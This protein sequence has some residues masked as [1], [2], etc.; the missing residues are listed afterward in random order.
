M[1]RKFLL[2]LL[3]ILLSSLFFVSLN[4]SDKSTATI[5]NEESQP[6]DTLWH[7]KHFLDW[8]KL[9]L[10]KQHQN[11]RNNIVVLKND[12]A[13]LPIGRLD[14][15]IVWVSF[16]GLSSG[17][18]QGMKNYTS[19]FQHF[20]IKSEI[21]LLHTLPKIH[22]SDLV[23][24][25][26]HGE[27]G[28]IHHEQWQLVDK[29]TPKNK[30][31]LV[32]FGNINGHHKEHQFQHFQSLVFAPDNHPIMQ[33]ETAQL[34]FGAFGASAK[35]DDHLNKEFP[36]GHGM[37]TVPNGRFSF[38][39]PEEFGISASQLKKMD[40]I[41]LNGIQ[42]GAYPGCQILATYKGSVIYNKCFGNK[43]YKGNDPVQASDVYDIASVTKIAA[44]TLLAM[45]LHSQ[46]KFDLNKKLGDYLGDWTKNTVY[47]SVS[48]KDMMA[49][50][51]GFTPW[52]PFYKTTLKNGKTNER[53]YS[54]EKKEGFT[55]QV[56]ANLFLRND[57]VDSMYAQIV[58][59]PLNTP[60]K[61]EYSDLCF[62]FVQRINELQT[63]RKQNDYLEKE[64]YRPMG[65]HR[66]GYLPYNRI[67]LT[68]IAPTENDKL[69][70]NQLIHGFV[71]DQGAAMLGGVGGH[72]GLFSNASDLAAIMQLFMHKGTYAGMNF[73]NTITTEEF[74]KQQ[75]SGNK[76]GAGFDRPNGG[77]GG[78]C[79]NSAS[80]KS[81][82]HSGFTGTLAWADPENEIIFVF[83]SNRVYPDAENWKIREMH[84]R[85]EI[86]EAFYSA[87][88]NRKI[89]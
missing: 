42:Q 9:S 67:P 69:F 60:K 89:N 41:A 77:G 29:I 85:T 49:H 11:A 82:G 36:L 25:S 14:K 78:I 38:R 84:I 50:Q 43:T 80:Q 20:H 40:E 70:R 7:H 35:L 65:L 1:S 54:T 53:I 81:F 23:L 62:Y 48:I 6:E 27:K 59:T 79:C 3:V 16:G 15:S 72:A 87:V 58:K 71:H 83:L 52:I 34:L 57:Y 8:N 5:A 21:D 13:L 44:S 55:V 47:N 68:E 22:S 4:A 31:V 76:R 64:I 37:T 33:N 63:G 24:V 46:N 45:H 88:K 32:L 51:A 75:F 2:S 39:S 30:A 10:S 61:Y 12:N 73:F 86:Q 19:V 74:T 26:L 66:I 18:E 17:F 56:A 28:K